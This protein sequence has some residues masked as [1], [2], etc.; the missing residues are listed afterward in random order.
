MIHLLK[1]QYLQQDSA[2]TEEFWPQKDQ[3][4]VFC[5]EISCNIEQHTASI[6]TI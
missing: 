1:L 5:L 4:F 6:G 2:T 3:H